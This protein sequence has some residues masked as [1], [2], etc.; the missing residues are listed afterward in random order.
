MEYSSAN[1]LYLCLLRHWILV[2]GGPWELAFR[3][4]YRHYWCSSNHCVLDQRWPPSRCHASILDRSVGQSRTFSLGAS[5]FDRLVLRIRSFA[6][7]AH[8][9]ASH[10][11]GP[12]AC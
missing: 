3:S 10:R 1:S 5:I 6:D 12:T 4:H 11:M 2:G 7:F 9:R 8:R